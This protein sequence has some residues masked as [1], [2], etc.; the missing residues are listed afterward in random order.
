MCRL[1]SYVSDSETNFPKVVGKN[2]QEFVQL[3]KVH[4]DGWGITDKN[5]EVFKEATPAYESKDFMSTLEKNPSQ[6]SLLHIRWA[7]SNLPVN[8]D[9]A[10]PFHYGD[11]SFIHNGSINPPTSLDSY[12]SPEYLKLAK[13]GNDSE[14]YFL[15]VVEKMKELGVVNGVKAAVKVIK[16]NTNYSSINAMLMTPEELIIINEHDNAKRPDFGSEDYYDLLFKN[17]GHSIV[18]GSSGW[19]QEGW[20]KIENHTIMVINRKNQAFS[21][22]NI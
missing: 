16:E 21:F 22:E 18:V 1:L 4:C 13:T 5:G 20:E 9:N 19:N 12:I 6:A 7:T 8:R 3:S 2:F 14:R 11:Y 15:L 17:D 10:H